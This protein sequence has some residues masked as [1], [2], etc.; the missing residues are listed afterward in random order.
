MYSTTTYSEEE[1]VMTLTLTAN[2]Y[3][4]QSEAVGVT[5]S[6]DSVTDCPFTID[7]TSDYIKLEQDGLTCNIKIFKSFLG[8][9]VTIKCESNSATD[10]VSDTCDIKYLGVPTSLDVTYNGANYSKGNACEVLEGS[11][12]DVLFDYDNY[13]GTIGNVEELYNAGLTDFHY[14][15]QLSQE[16]TV[17]CNI[18]VCLG[19]KTQ[20]ISFSHV[21]PNASE[22]SVV[23]KY[24]D[25]LDTN[26]FD[27]DQISVLQNLA[28][29]TKVQYE[30]NYSSFFRNSS[31]T[32]LEN[33]DILFST[34][35]TSAVRLNKE[36]DL[37]SKYKTNES[38]DEGTFAEGDF[39][40]Y[41][42]DLSNLEFWVAMGSG[43]YGQ[44]AFS[45]YHYTKFMLSP[46]AT[47]VTFS[48]EEVI[49]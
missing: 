18:T 11:Q 38:F 20:V 12:V 40:K 33:N 16:G 27:E 17:K 37:Y 43:L 7:D 4:I 45:N 30:L 25:L 35:L 42:F 36:V 46:I 49:I 39:I 3:P 1:K 21:I 32:V 6:I 10:K 24:S 23:I 13:F 34:T 48:E 5:Y 41:E 47:D 9:T 31:K 29:F 28:I 44:G 26:I 19:G 15:P 2:V 14:T 22:N 8:G